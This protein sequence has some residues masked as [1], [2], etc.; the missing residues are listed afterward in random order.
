MDITIHADASKRK[1]DR[2]NRQ[3][4]RK[5]IVTA[6]ANLE[7]HEI[8]NLD[9]FDSYGE[10][11][12]R[13]FGTSLKKT[14][15]D[16]MVDGVLV[17]NDFADEVIA[18]CVHEDRVS[19]LHVNSSHN[20]Y[21]G[22]YDPDPS[23]KVIVEYRV[24]AERPSLIVDEDGALDRVDTEELEARFSRV[25]EGAL[26]FLEQRATELKDLKQTERLSKSIANSAREE[27][28]GATKYES[29]LKALEEE[30]EAK[31][32]ALKA[33]VKQ[34]TFEA[35]RNITANWDDEVEECLE[36]GFSQKATQSAP[37]FWDRYVTA[38]SGG[39]AKGGIFMGSTASGRPEPKIGP[40]DLGYSE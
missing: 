3:Y 2:R 39:V 8:E 33:E 5:V 34:E 15:I 20:R 36:A 27:A 17:A 23:V 16:R 40:E 32:A 25:V 10:E 35:G 4:Y 38:P 31:V 29:R 28:V 6:N 14:D 13:F 19:A 1:D 12:K 21:K 24:Y 18:H 22:G 26:E 11:H 37:K 9:A 7:G 30:F